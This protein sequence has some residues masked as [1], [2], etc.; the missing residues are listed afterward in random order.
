MCLRAGLQHGSGS[1][2]GAGSQQGAGAGS[3]HGAGSQQE[4]FLWKRPAEAD[5]EKL[6]ATATKATDA[7]KRRMD[8]SPKLKTW[9]HFPRPT[10]SGCLTILAFIQPPT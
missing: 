9:L 5:E 8:L 4:L 6:T 7:I 3:Q 10:H 2:H 1:Q